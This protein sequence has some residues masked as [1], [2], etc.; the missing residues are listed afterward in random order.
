MKQTYGSKDSYTV[1]EAAKEM[2]MTVEKVQGL[3]SGGFLGFK[4]GINGPVISASAM[5]SY[6]LGHKPRSEPEYKPQ[7]PR[8]KPRKIYPKARSRR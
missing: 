5:N 7:K 3:I 6:Y 8:R 1:I 2:K 4:A